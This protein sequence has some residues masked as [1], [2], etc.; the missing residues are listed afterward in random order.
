M[1]PEKTRT[2]YCPRCGRHDVETYMDGDV[3]K[4]GLHRR[5]GSEETCYRGSRRPV[6]R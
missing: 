5:K 2:A 4:Y 3:E 1:T 6:Q